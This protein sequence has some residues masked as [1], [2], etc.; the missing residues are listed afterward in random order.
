MFDSA[1]T[2][3]RIER[4]RRADREIRS[5]AAPSRTLLY[6]AIGTWL[7]ATVGRAVTAASESSGS[8]SRQAGVFMGTLVTTLLVVFIVR[9]V[10]RLVRRRP[11]LSP[12]W[13]PS[14]FFTAAGLSLLLLASTAGR[15]SG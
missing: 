12:A 5:E 9:S 4:F 14:L 13:T 3:E 15:E 6:V 1:A 10:V 2:Y 11:I 7:L 8:A